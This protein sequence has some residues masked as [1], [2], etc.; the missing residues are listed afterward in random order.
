MTERTCFAGDALGKAIDADGLD[1]IGA[2]SLG[3]ERP[4]ADGV[5]SRAGRRFGLAG[6][7][8]L[9]DAQINRLQENPIRNHL[10]AGL[11][12]SDIAH[13][14]LRGR[15]RLLDAAAP[16][17][18]PRSHEQREPL[19]LELR[20]NLL[21]DADRRVRDNHAEKQ[22]IAPIPERERERTKPRQ[23]R[24]EDGHDVGA[25]DA[26]VGPADGPLALSTATGEPRARLRIAE[27][28]QALPSGCGAARRFDLRASAYRAHRRSPQRPGRLI[29]SDPR[30]TPIA[31]HGP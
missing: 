23:N 20:S 14:D 10:L 19:Q 31:R 22:G 29:Q 25:D 1:A 30:S 27:A 24:V 13:D 2:G 17:P 26:R 9:V 8:R 11:K 15:D 3:D 12:E 6:E 18:R 28:R 16:Y 7:N 4:G 5:A 21:R